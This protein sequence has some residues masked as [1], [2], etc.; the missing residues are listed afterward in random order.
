MVFSGVVWSTSR[1]HANTVKSGYCLSIVTIASQHTLA[2]HFFTFADGQ[3]G[4]PSDSSL[5]PCMRSPWCS[6]Y[7]R[8]NPVCGGLL[9]IDSSDSESRLAIVLSTLSCSST[10]CLK[11]TGAYHRALQGRYK[12]GIMDIVMPL[13]SQIFTVNILT[14]NI[15]IHFTVILILYTEQYDV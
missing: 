4:G 6:F 11:R 3:V 7:S 1:L 15:P 2:G 8:E 10:L 13:T 14:P 9:T 12:M 5:L